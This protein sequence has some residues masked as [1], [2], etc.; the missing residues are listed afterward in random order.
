MEYIRKNTWQDVLDTIKPPPITKQK[1]ARAG[2]LAVFFIE[3][4]Q[5]AWTAP[6]LH[7][8]AHVYGG[9]DVSLVIVCGTENELFVKGITKDWENVIYNVMPFE[10]RTREEYNELLTSESFWDLFMSH[11]HVLLFQTDT[12]IRKPVDTEMFK[13]AYVGAPWGWYPNGSKSLVGNGGFSLRNVKV[14]KDVCNKHKY[15]PITDTAEDVYFSK[16][17]PLYMLPNP[18]LARAFAVEHIPHHDPCGLHQ[19]WRFHK[20]QDLAKLLNGIPGSTGRKPPF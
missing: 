10:N 17:V 18:E 16:H 19:A 20:T 11:E 4:R 12:L 13:Y 9:L 15:D 1:W 5:H 8:M 7:N 14:M 3:F 6:V 2:K